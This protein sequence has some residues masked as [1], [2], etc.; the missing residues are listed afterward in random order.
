MH[1]DS[2]VQE[3]HLALD[4]TAQRI[5]LRPAAHTPSS[6]STLQHK[7]SL[8]R[9]FHPTSSPDLLT[10]SLPPKK[11]PSLHAGIVARV[12]E[13]AERLRPVVEVLAILR[14]ASGHAG[15]VLAQAACKGPDGAGT[16]SNETS[17]FGA[18][19]AR[20]IYQIPW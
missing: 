12:G 9:G 15:S 19:R 2:L 10:R 17:L 13:H 18:C 8:A 16:S 7:L 3:L 5:S 20:R 6:P 1:P 4:Y 11:L 14:P